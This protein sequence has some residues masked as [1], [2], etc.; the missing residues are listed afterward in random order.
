MERGTLIR[1]YFVLA[2]ISVM[3]KVYMFCSLKIVTLFDKHWQ[4]LSYE[5]K[6]KKTNQQKKQN[7][8]NRKFSENYSYYSAAA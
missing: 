8:M 2:Y 7:Y 5:G 3:R 1:R 4:L 6:K